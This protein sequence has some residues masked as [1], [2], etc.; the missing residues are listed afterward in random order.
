M[1]NDK[2]YW[3]WFE[4]GV[5]GFVLTFCLQYNNAYAT[6]YLNANIWTSYENLLCILCEI[7]ENNL[8]ICFSLSN[9][10]K[11][12]YFFFYLKMDFMKN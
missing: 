6:F 7:D 8:E 10:Q 4:I 5:F 12:S 2:K 9:Y 3:Y 1:K 11:G